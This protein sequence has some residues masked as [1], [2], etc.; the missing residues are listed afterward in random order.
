MLIASEEK[1]GMLKKYEEN[2]DKIKY[3]IQVKKNNEMIM[4]IKI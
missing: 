2:F 3:L 1:E 4:V